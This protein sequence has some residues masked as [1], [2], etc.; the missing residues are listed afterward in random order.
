MIRVFPKGKLD[1]KA[2]AAIG[3][4]VVER[5]CEESSYFRQRKTFRARGGQETSPHPRRGRAEGDETWDSLPLNQAESALAVPAIMVRLPFMFVLW[6]LSAVVRE[7]DGVMATQDC[8][9][10]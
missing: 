7:L 2:K 4:G 6:N 3:F 1:G 8:S 10:G 5:R 9:G